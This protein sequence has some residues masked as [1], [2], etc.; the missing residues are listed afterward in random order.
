MVPW[1]TK[2]GSQPPNCTKRLS[3]YSR[4]IA[5]RLQDEVGPQN[6]AK[7]AFGVWSMN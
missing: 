2:Y 3:S 5:F 6:G 1:I 4:V 7:Q